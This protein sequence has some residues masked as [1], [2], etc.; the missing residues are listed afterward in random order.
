M[1]K[2]LKK[3]NKR[4]KKELKLA[5]ILIRNAVSPIIFSGGNSYVCA[6]IEI[7]L[8]NAKDLGAYQGALVGEIG[9]VRAAWD[10]YHEAHR[11]EFEMPRPKL[12]AEGAP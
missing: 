1:S 7:W 5:R 6:W 12:T 8:R 9:E 2:K 3:A 11:D 10:L 4:L